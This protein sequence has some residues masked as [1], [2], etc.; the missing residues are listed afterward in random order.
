L[1]ARSASRPRGG[2]AWPVAVSKNYSHAWNTPLLSAHS[3]QYTQIGVEYY[4]LARQGYLSG[5][6]PVG[7]NLFHH[8]FEM[9]FKAEL[10][11]VGT[12]PKKVW[13]NYRHDLKKLW[14]DF[15]ALAKGMPNSPAPQLHTFDPLI[16]QLHAWED[17]RYP[18]FPSGKGVA[19]RGMLR[20]ADVNQS[21][22]GS[23]AAQTSEYVINLEAMDELFSAVVAAAPFGCAFIRSHLAVHRG[24]LEIYERKNLHPIPDSP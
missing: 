13:N 12:P 5:F 14:P 9:L 6:L 2:I 17:I 10:I 11:E 24:A 16:D 1:V 7:P 8:T 3:Y 19:M 21:V 15:K 4:V 18:T 22:G 20:K 23:A